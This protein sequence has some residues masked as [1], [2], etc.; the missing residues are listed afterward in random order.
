MKD[1]DPAN[2]SIDWD[3]LSER[4]R[5]GQL[6]RKLMRLAVTLT[7][8]AI[9]LLGINLGAICWLRFNVNALTSVRAPALE[10]ARQAQYGV[11][12][13]L[14][15][16]RGWIAVGDDHFLSDRV[17]AWDQSIRPAA[18]R[19]HALTRDA[20]EHYLGVEPLLDDLAELQWWVVDVAQTPGNRPAHTEYQR[21]ALPIRQALQASLEE[22]VKASGQADGG[23]QTQHALGILGLFQL[24]LANADLSLRS[25]METGSGGDLHAFERH[26]EDTRRTLKQLHTVAQSFDAGQMLHLEAIAQEFPWYAKHVRHVAALRGTPDWNVAQRLM[27]QQVDPLARKITAHFDTVA[28]HQASLM[29]DQSRHVAIAGTGALVLSLVLIALMAGLAVL[30]SRRRADEITAPVHR[31]SV[32][33]SE[34]ASG[35]LRTDVPVTSNDE[36]GKLTYA[37]NYM[38]TRIQRTEA[39]L[40][41]INGLMQSELDAAADYVRSVLPAPNNFKGGIRADWSFIASSSLGGDSFGY[42]WIDDRHFAIYLLDVSGHGIGSSL[43]SISAYNTLRQRTLPG[44]DF[45]NPSD[46]LQSLNEAFQMHENNNKFFTIWYGV[47]D[48]HTRELTSACGGHHPSVLFDPTQQHPQDVGTSNLI[49]GVADDIDFESETVVIPPGSRLYVFSD[50]AIEAMDPDNKL[51]TQERLTACLHSA[52]AKNDG[53]LQHVLDTVRQWTGQTALEDDYTMLEISFD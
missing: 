40:Q 28:A 43:L 51:F 32:A 17:D 37:F 41:K 38:R 50:C 4:F 22:I 26:L 48:S 25:Y 27:E 13:S 33:A 24:Q 46:V 49:I 10:A 30:L 11:E 23:P 19:I 42:H 9:V 16:V 3:S 39:N 34:V 31:L 20:S 29:D 5:E 2:D 12:K 18:A 52:Q 8:M 21:R 44:V 6:R 45:R 53:R 36:I 35:A 15:S 47:Y 1:L 7:A 14:S